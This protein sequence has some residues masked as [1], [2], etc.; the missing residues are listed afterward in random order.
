VR[1]R[2]SKGKTSKTGRIWS[3]FEHVDQSSVV[4]ATPHRQTKALSSQRIPSSPRK[5]APTIPHWKYSRSGIGLTAPTPEESLRITEA[6]SGQ[7]RDESGFRVAS[8]H[9]DLEGRCRIGDA[10]I[11][12]YDKHGW[13]HITACGTP[14]RTPSMT[15]SS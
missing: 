4:M 8:N 10:P 7:P 1:D 9:L 14:V 3:R 5:Q 6:R 2:K 11:A 15:R 13:T 12:L